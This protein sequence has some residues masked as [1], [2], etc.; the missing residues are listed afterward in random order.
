LLFF[1][2]LSEELYK[3]RKALHPKFPKY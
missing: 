2:L 3:I 1:E